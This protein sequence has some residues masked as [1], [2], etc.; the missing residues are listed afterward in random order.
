MGNSYDKYL[1]LEERG[2]FEFD[3]TNVNQVLYKAAD[4]GLKSQLLYKA[5]DFIRENPELTNDDAILLAAKEFKL[6]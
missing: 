1:E 3:P 6:I 2:A 4:R 5:M